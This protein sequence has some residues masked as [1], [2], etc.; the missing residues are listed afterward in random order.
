MPTRVLRVIARMN[1]G[2]PAIHASLLTR[3]LDPARYESWLVTGVPSEDEGDYLKFRGQTL[4]RVVTIPGLG[5]EI[6]PWRDWRAYRALQRVIRE[7]KPAIVHT[8]TAK[9]GVL[10]RLAA[11]REGVPIVIHTFHGHVLKGYFSRSKERMFVQAERIAARASTRL[12]T[13]SEVV[14]DE[15]LERGIGRPEQFDVIRLGFDLAPFIASGRHAGAFRAEL[16]VDSKTPLIAI[17]A[18]LVP[19]KAHE[20]FLEMAA[21]VATRHPT[22]RFVIVG[23]GERRAAL[24]AD[25]RSHGLGERVHFLGWRADLDKIYADVNVVVLTSRN[26]GSPVA[27][28]EAMA[29]G[30]PVV[31]TRAGGVA[32]LVG[33]A[34]LLREV[35]DAAGL[36]DDVLRLISDA[37]LADRLGEAGR[38]RVVPLYSQDRLLADIDRLY[39]RCLAERNL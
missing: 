21:R 7:V 12:V 28:I 34:G 25:A 32:E 29:C 31:A 13:V 16:G 37:A 6:Q 26:E 19:I 5:R 11:R 23:D 30:R 4:D 27:L 14:R 8:H 10:G 17:V 24:E 39:C 36:A 38:V 3:G 9:A 18:R 15:L 33:D 35:D 2:G 22:A 1:I 20:I